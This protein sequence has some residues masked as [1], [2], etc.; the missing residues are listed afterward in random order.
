MLLNHKK[1]PIRISKFFKVILPKSISEA[2]SFKSIKSTI[3]DRQIIYQLN[4]TADTIIFYKKGNL[5]MYNRPEKAQSQI[6]IEYL[7]SN[8]LP[9]RIKY[10]SENHDFLIY[11]ADEFIFIVY[12]KDDNGPKDSWTW[13]ILLYNTKNNSWSEYSRTFDKSYGGIYGFYYI[14]KCR[15][16]IF[17]VGKTIFSDEVFHNVHNT[18]RG[19]KL[20][21]FYFICLDKPKNDL[22]FYSSYGF[23][24]IYSYLKEYIE[25]K[26]DGKC[27]QILQ[28]IIDYTI[29]VNNGVIY[30][31]CRSTCYS[32]GKYKASIITVQYN[33]CTDNSF[34]SFGIEAPIPMIKDVSDCKNILLYLSNKRLRSKGMPKYLPMYLSSEFYDFMSNKLFHADMIFSSHSKP[35]VRDKHFNRVSTV[36]AKLESLKFSAH[37]PLQEDMIT[38]RGGY[39]N[40]VLAVLLIC[41][42]CIVGLLNF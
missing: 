27:D 20:Q 33:V 5:N 42:L 29:D 21:D 32:N 19:F 12:S 14:R 38:M 40:K 9:K 30:M 13:N 23:L 10:V 3:I 34:K 6:Q 15:K 7:K 39:N 35:L 24:Y 22:H 28:A 16:V 31:V 37:I 18:R 26:Y 11:L 25:A 4:G 1:P 36:L 2:P 41:D 17:A 8:M